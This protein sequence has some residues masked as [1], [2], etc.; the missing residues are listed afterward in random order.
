[1]KEAIERGVFVVE[2]AVRSPSSLLLPVSLSAVAFDDSPTETMVP[3]DGRAW[4]LADATKEVLWALKHGDGRMS[5]IIK[6][7]ETCDSIIA[8]HAARCEAFT[9]VPSSAAGQR[10]FDIHI[11]ALRDAIEHKNHLHQE[12]S[13][14]KG[15]PR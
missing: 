15:I 10:S 12:L 4:T 6:R 9:H 13:V 7:I 1:M 8:F 11:N 5:D 14:S 3:W 2:R